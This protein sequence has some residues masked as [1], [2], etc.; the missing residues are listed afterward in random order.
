MSHR[1]STLA[2][3]IYVYFQTYGHTTILEIK[4]CVSDLYT[5]VIWLF[6]YGH[7]MALE[8]TPHILNAIEIMA[9][10]YLPRISAAALS[11]LV[12]VQ[13]CCSNIGTQAGPIRFEYN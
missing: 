13:I 7:I 11:L 5:S 6:C 1:F 8:T 3:H 12:G 9:E 10:Y 4:S 2:C